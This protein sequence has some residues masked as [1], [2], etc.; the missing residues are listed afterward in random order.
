MASVGLIPRSRLQRIPERLRLAH[1]YCYF[2]HDEAV[3]L[4]KQYEAAKASVVEIKFR[5]K[6]DA[7]AFAR[8]QRDQDPVTVLRT[9]GYPTEAQRVVL[10]TITIA[11]VSDV[12]VSSA[13]SFASPT[14]IPAWARS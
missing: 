9:I 5:G 7:A 8:L 2:L 14:S 13:R 3:R 1:E 10:N 4:L 12:H 11:M 6:R